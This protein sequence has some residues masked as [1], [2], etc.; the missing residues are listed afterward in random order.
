MS[1]T[2]DQDLGDTAGRLPGSDLAGLVDQSVQNLGDGTS[3]LPQDVRHVGGTS[4]TVDT[5]EPAHTPLTRNQ[6]NTLVHTARAEV[7]DRI[8]RNSAIMDNLTF[9]QRTVLSG[10]KGRPGRAVGRYAT[11]HPLGMPH[12]LSPLASRRA[13]EAFVNG[14]IRGIEKDVALRRALT[15][16]S[17]A[18][19]LRAN[20]RNQYG[21]LKQL[22]VLN[23]QPLRKP[24]TRSITGQEPTRYLDQLNRSNFQRAH[25]VRRPGRDQVRHF[26]VDSLENLRT[27]RRRKDYEESPHVSI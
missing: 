8:L 5:L 11:R 26:A 15:R 17:L 16:W 12:A 6:M 19:S 7:F 2:T 9:D 25:Y 14:R 10:Y 20:P 13:L 18:E 27:R 1:D 23:N 3:V 4:Y 21:F 24:G 22:A